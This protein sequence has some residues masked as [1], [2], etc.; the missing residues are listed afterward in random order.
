M[1]TKLKAGLEGTLRI[2]VGAKILLEGRT[3]WRREGG[4]GITQKGANT[5]LA[6]AGRQTRSVN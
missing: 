4:K 3:K 1:R 5:N 6:R 2:I